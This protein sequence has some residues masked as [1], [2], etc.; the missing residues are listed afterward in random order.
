MT[1]EISMKVFSVV[2]E[3]ITLYWFCILNLER[4][5]YSKVSVFLVLVLIGI[6]GLTLNTIVPNKHWLLFG[7]FV[8]LSLI[9]LVLFTGK[10]TLKL[11][12]LVI[13]MV[14]GVGAEVAIKSFSVFCY[15][16]LASFNARLT[17]DQIR[18]TILS[19]FLTLILIKILL[20]RKFN[21]AEIATKTLVM[22][23][24]FPFATVLSFNRLMM[25]SYLVDNPKEYMSSF[26]TVCVLI[27]ANIIIFY[28]F[29]AQVDNEVT[30]RR[31]AVFQNAQKS[32][33]KYY[34]SIIEEKQQTNVLRHELKHIL[35]A[36]K[37]YLQEEKLT[38]AIA[39][40]EKMIGNFITVE[41]PLTQNLAIDIVLNEKKQKAASLKIKMVITTLVGEIK[42]NDID[43][44]VLLADALENAIEAASGIGNAV[45][46]VSLMANENHIDLQIS[47]PV[48]NP[49]KIV[50]GK[51]ETTKAEKD[52]HGIGLLTIQEIV[53]RYNGYMNLK[54]EEGIFYLD[55]TMN[56]ISMD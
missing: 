19:K 1:I 36:L 51:I 29:E 34:A 38:D 32:Q 49:V 10:I 20:F 12:V 26:M 43:L 15:G 25:A 16:D 35:L 4:K 5:K 56:N 39:Y 30:K 6:L 37:G 54:A 7:N 52:L 3:V 22:L 24:V 41:V 9:P 27:L 55:I 21:Q 8:I 23:M 45:I 42:V 47:N 18:G 17:I 11:F 48:V 14:I 31:F 28:L 2:M 50:D 33:E 44:A 46:R 13:F 53:T 40:I